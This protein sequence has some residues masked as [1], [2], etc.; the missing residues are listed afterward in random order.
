[1]P[2]K[3]NPFRPNPGLD[4]ACTNFDRL[5]RELRQDAEEAAENEGKFKSLTRRLKA[6]HYDDDRWSSLPDQTPGR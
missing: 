4:T 1:M 3:H 5:V 2:D 6:L